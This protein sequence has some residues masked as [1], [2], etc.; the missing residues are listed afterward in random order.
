SRVARL[1][2]TVFGQLSSEPIAQRISRL[3]DAVPIETAA[4]S[5]PPTATSLA[6]PKTS[7]NFQP[8]DQPAFQPDRVPSGQANVNPNPDANALSHQP[9]GFYDDPDSPAPSENPAFTNPPNASYFGSSP[10]DADMAAA[11]TNLEQKLFGQTYPM[12]SIESRLS[13]LEIK[14]FQQPA[15]Q[16]ATIAQRFERLV[17]V[18]A[19]D[20]HLNQPSA[21]GGGGF[22]GTALPVIIMLLPLLL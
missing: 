17:A 10:E 1:E 3:C 15:P 2:E 8:P 16:G 13:R 19:T 14:L 11:L 18:A 21:I 7:P 6:E 22:W 20:K 9:T 12:E 5:R 4:I